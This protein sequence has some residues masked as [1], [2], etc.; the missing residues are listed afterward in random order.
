MDLLVVGKEVLDV[1]L[2]QRA[3]RFILWTTVENLTGI[4]KG[5]NYVYYY[6]FGKAII[7]DSCF[8]S[9]LASSSVVAGTAQHKNMWA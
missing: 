7:D 2:L 3:R 4:K 8:C 9:P 5:L 6:F 1:S